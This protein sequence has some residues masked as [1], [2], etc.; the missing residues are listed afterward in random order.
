M[1][2]ARLGRTAVWTVFFAVAGL[3]LADAAEATAKGEAD[4]SK[5]RELVATYAKAVD[6]ADLELAAQVWADGPDVS[7]IHPRGHERGWEGV[8]GFFRDTMGGLFSE[9]KLTVKDLVV[10]AY[11]D[12]GWAEFYWE[13]AARWRKDGSPVAT[14]G[15]E[16]QIYRKSGAGWRLVHVHYS[17]MPVTGE[18]QGF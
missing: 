11:G 8:K 2:G 4:A 6:A 18:R 1:R 15:R 12:A 14:A 3:R 7:F 10:H 5:I 9:R 17:A 16:T 13:F